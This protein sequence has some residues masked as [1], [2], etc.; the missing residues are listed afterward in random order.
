MKFALSS[1]LF[2]TAFAKSFKIDITKVPK[3]TASGAHRLQA[4]N[5]VAH[6]RLGETMQLQE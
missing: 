1:L 5:T 6:N 2:A 3:A 4:A